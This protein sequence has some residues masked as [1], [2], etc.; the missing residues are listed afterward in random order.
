MGN[1]KHLNLFANPI[2]VLIPLV[3]IACTPEAE[4]AQQVST[5]KVTSGWLIP[6]NEIKKGGPGKDGIPALQ[7]PPVQM[8]QVL[9]VP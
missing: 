4:I 9:G 7:N 1:Q 8:V 6:E 2:V 3:W 5:E